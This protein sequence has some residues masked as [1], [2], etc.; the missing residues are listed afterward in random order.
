MIYQETRD[1]TDAEVRPLST[2][3]DSAAVAIGNARFID[4]TQQARE[5]AESRERRT[6]Q[7]YEVTAQLASNHDLDSVLDLITHQATELMSGRAGA[8]YKFDE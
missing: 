3:A 2:L 4:E 6:A 7:L 1:F 8:I 5:D